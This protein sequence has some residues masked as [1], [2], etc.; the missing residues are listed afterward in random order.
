MKKQKQILFHFF[1]FFLSFSKNFF[2]KI[3]SFVLL[4]SSIFNLKE[5]TNTILIISM[6]LNP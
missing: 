4:R 3:L 1:R 2:N 6:Y 5:N